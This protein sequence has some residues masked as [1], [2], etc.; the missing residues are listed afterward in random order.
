[1]WLCYRELLKKRT[2]ATQLPH[3]F[4]ICGM[5]GVYYWVV[6]LI[7]LI[8]WRLQPLHKRYPDRIARVV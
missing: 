5:F 2:H 4:I 8:L 3:T 7:G 1:M 6:P